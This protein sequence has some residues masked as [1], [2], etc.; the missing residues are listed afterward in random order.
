MNKLF[1]PTAAKSLY[2]K[3]KSTFDSVAEFP[4]MFPLHPL[5]QISEMGFHYC[6]IGNYLAFYTVDDDEQTVYARA[7]VYGR[8][9]L[10][11]AFE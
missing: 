8:I 1:D 5:E 9:D 11:K 3:V 2:E 7:M 4:E 6:Q 10:N